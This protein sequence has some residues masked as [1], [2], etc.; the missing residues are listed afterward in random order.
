MDLVAFSSG[1]DLSGFWDVA[2]LAERIQRVHGGFV[3]HF[4]A[5]AGQRR[6]SE[7]LRV[8]RACIV[9]LK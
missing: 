6:Y 3:D 4:N 2:A 9:R 1:L 8:I 7:D 5:L